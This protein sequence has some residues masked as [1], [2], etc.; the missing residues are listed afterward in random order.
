MGSSIQTTQ[1]NQ[2]H[3]SRIP[4]RT[5]NMRALIPILL[6]AAIHC[7]S[8]QGGYVHD[9]SGDD[10]E[11][12]VHDP[13]WDLTPFQL[14]QIKK[15]GV[16][17]QSLSQNSISRPAAPRKPAYTQQPYQSY[18]Q[19]TNTQYQTYTPPQQSPSRSSYQFT[20]SYQAAAPSYQA[21]APQTADYIAQ[22]T[23]HPDPNF[24]SRA[25][26]YTAPKYAA[27]AEGSSYT[28]EAIF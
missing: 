17:P 8:G 4:F 3:P 28:Y 5:L 26:A 18:Q 9:P 22:A 16:S 6:V 1:G 20:S 19:P 11:P 14:Y 13:A 21:A 24:W 12:Y 15:K 27:K 10:G 23:R 25:Y 7:Q 2:C